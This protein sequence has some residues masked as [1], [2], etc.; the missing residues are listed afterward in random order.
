MALGEGRLYS[1]L[2]ADESMLGVVKTKLDAACEGAIGRGWFS[3]VRDDRIMVGPS[4]LPRCLPRSNLS[5]DVQ[6]RLLDEEA[7]TEFDDSRAAQLA[8][9]SALAGEVHL[10]IKVRY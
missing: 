6:H 1:T 7:R 4:T 9:A 2:V 10:E 8:V 3:S 5:I